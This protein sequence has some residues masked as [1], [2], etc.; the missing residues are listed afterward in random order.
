M[1]RF[2]VTDSGFDKTIEITGSDVNHAVNVLRLKK[3]DIVTVCD[4]RSNDYTCRISEINEKSII[5]DIEDIERSYAEL[6]VNIT[7]FQGLPKGDK[8]EFIIQKA[9]ELGAVSVYPVIMQRSVVKIDDKKKNKKTERYAA[10]AE[11]A[12]KQSRRGIIPEIPGIIDYKEAI[13]IAKSFDTIL[14]P[15]EEAEGIEASRSLLEDI[16]K[17][18]KKGQTI[19]IFIGPEGGFTKEEVQMAEEAGAN[20]ITLGNRI[21]RTETAGMMLLSVLSFLMEE[22]GN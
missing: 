9:V 1:H 14:L 13:R 15:Y 19:G 20:V 3:D 7:L 17:N 11:S 4:G 21:L 18:H 5:C 10:V 22:K 6:P 12:A 2:Y 16:C 8:M